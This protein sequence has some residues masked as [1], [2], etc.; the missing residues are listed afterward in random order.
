MNT[1]IICQEWF[2]S[3]W[4]V[5]VYAVARCERIVV[6]PCD[7]SGFVKIDGEERPVKM[8]NF[9]NDSDFHSQFKEV[10]EWVEEDNALIEERET[11]NAKHAAE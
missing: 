8:A 2:I 9:A 4:A 1:Y 3:R 6:P 10:E 7:L 11:K 5:C